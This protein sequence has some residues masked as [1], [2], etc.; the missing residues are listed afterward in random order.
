VD[1]PAGDD[2]V[3]HSVVTDVDNRCGFD[4]AGGH[5]AG[6]GRRTGFNVSLDGSFLIAIDGL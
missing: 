1:D 2:D 6:Y 5:D 3:A 4:Q